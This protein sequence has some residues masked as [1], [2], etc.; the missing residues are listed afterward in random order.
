MNSG[1]RWVLALSA[2]AVVLVG[3]VPRAQ[4]PAN[5][6]TP[7][8]QPASPGGNGT[9]PGDAAPGRGGRGRGG[10]DILAGGPQLD[11]PAYGAVDFAKK[12]PVLPLTPDKQ[13]TRF[14]LQPGYRLELRRQSSLRSRLREWKH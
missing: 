7:Q 8:A 1:R 10:P 14:I 12:D 3:L 11:D 13:L 6:T 9:P 2:I 5:N 4:T